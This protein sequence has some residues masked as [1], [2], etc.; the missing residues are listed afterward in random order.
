MP[1]RRPDAD[2]DVKMGGVREL[3]SQAEEPARPRRRQRN[4]DDLDLDGAWS[5]D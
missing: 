5:R 4:A 1:K 3:L 2:D